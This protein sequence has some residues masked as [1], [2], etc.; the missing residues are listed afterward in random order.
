MFYPTN[1]V[2]TAHPKNTGAKNHAFI[3]AKNDLPREN[4]FMPKYSARVCAT[5]EKL[6]LVP[7][8][9]PPLYALAVNK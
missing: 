4:P 2:G 6:S 7:R 8:F 1:L 9:T 5:S 3:S